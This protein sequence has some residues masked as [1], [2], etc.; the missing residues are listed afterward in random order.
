MYLFNCNN[1]RWII[2]ICESKKDT[3]KMRN[4]ILPNVLLRITKFKF[5]FRWHLNFKI[6]KSFSLRVA[7]TEWNN[8]RF[9]WKLRADDVRSSNKCSLVRVDHITVITVNTGVDGWT[10]QM[11]MMRFNTSLCQ[12]TAIRILFPVEEITEF[13]KTRDMDEIAN[14]WR[15][16]GYCNKI[17]SVFYLALIKVWKLY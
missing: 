12:V 3:L 5:K 2:V 7:T 4:S 8:D 11:K 6:P 13:L 10:F 9:S 17:K 16:I 14:F 15:S 1:S